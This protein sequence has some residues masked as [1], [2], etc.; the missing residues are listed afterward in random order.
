MTNP[1][2]R[3]VLYVGIGIAALVILG[4]VLVVLYRKKKNHEK[5]D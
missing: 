2:T 3:T 4:T 1:N 5:E